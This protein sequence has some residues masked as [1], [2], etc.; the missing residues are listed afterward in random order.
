M[1]RKIN[2]NRP[3]VSADEIK[4]KRNF[5]SVLK[6]HATVSKP[7]FK[8]PW[9]LSGAI[10]ASVAIIATVLFLNRDAHVPQEAEN[11]DDQTKAI[12]TTVVDSLKQEEFYKS[13]EAK[14]IAPPITGLNVAFTTY[15]VNAEKGGSLDFKTGSKLVVPKN[16]FVDESGKQIKG[17]VELRYR[18]FHD[19]VDFFVSGIPMTYDSA[20]IRY[21]FE[22]AG[23]IEIQGFKDG[24]PVKMAEGKSIQVEMASNYSGT[25][26][27]LYA[28]DTVKNNWSCLGKDKVVSKAVQSN[29]G[30]KTSP[31]PEPVPESQLIANLNSQTEV[32]KAEAQTTKEKQIAAL[33]IVAPEPKKPAKAKKEN[34][35]FNI[36]VDPKEYPE[37]AIYKGV[38]FEVG[39]ENKKFDNSFY[40]G[41]WDEAT[42]KDGTKK[43]EN[44]NLTL[45]RGKEKYDVIVYPVF[46]GKNY[47]VAMQDYQDKFNKYG[48][49][50]E[51][52]KADEKRIEEAF[53]ARMEKIKL[54]QEEM[55]RAQKKMLEMQTAS[56]DTQTKVFRVF[57]VSGF[58]VYNCDNPSAYPKGASCNALFAN[59][60]GNKL[61]TYQFYLADKKKNGLFTYTR[62]P[63]LRFSFDPQSK[64]MLWAVEDGVLYILRPEQ[65]KDIKSGDQ[66]IKMEK[67]DR[68][69]ANTDELKTFF[70]L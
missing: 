27:N 5:D 41:T 49:A 65:F 34:F 12:A 60:M 61:Y 59:D 42:I 9:F 69:F 35:T 31:M 20:G 29:A 37:L 25:E 39:K 32:K 44:Y 11:G 28:L 70:S 7:F 43:G 54:E 56:I 45:V 15:K 68:K 8:K 24:M 50:L 52:R 62:N 22:S 38:L 53:Q 1:K 18:E 6:N 66:T 10:V 26:Y 33:P 2:I 48:T 58:G 36:E 4:Q 63:T 57:T 30:T 47:E 19:A 51:K 67:V 46:D 13:E 55:A 40:K 16:S 64:N 23:M 17:E 3:P 21:Q 14:C